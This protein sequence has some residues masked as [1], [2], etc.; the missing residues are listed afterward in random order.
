MANGKTYQNIQITVDIKIYRNIH[1]VDTQ[2]YIS[3]CPFKSTDHKEHQSI[4]NKCFPSRM[5]TQNA[6]V[7]TVFTYIYRSP[8][9][10]EYTYDRER[11]SRQK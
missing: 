3:H 5:K 11:Q 7:E 2:L 10:L 6:K 8:K 1:T 9:L 4:Q